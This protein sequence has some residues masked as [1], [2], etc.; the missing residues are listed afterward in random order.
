MAL[1]SYQEARSLVEL[2]LSPVYHYQFSSIAKVLDHIAVDK[3]SYSA[4]QKAIQ[5]MCMPYFD[6]PASRQYFLFQ[7]DTTPVCKPFS[8]TL[9]D[10]TY[11][12]TPNNFIP[13][14]KPLSIGY[15]LSFVN[16]SDTPSAWSLPLSVKRVGIDQ[17]AS[18][19]ALE[20]LK[21]LFAHRDLGLSNTLVINT[22]DSKY[23]NARYLAPAHQHEHLVNIV[24]LRSGIKVWKR[25]CRSNTGGAQGVYGEKYY[26]YAQGQ[27]KTYRHPKTKEPHQVLQRSLFDLQADE[28]LQLCART[29]KGRK[30]LIELWRWN[31]MMIRTRNGHQMKNKPF[32]LIAVRVSDLQNG[33]PLFEREMFI[34]I[35]GKRKAE[36][37]TSQGYEIY[38]HRYNIEPYLRFVKQRLLLE[39]YQTPVLEHFDNW[40]L[41]LQLATWLLYALSDQV[42]FRPRKWEQYLPQNKQ[43]KSAPRL[44][45]AQAR[46]AAEELF[47]TF[48]QTPFK[49]KKSK[50]GKGRRK[51]QAFIPRKRYKVAKKTSKKPKL[52]LKT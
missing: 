9:Q 36:I 25:H 7:T 52:E 11:V 5:G 22:L 42:P 23:G 39:Q 20:Q 29:T 6:P 41:I 18:E 50:K 38:R 48:E 49:P 32:D 35:C 17:T 26:L 27:Y 3:A 15:E 46:K 30:L 4:V 33:L 37:S 44:S 24:R 13:G 45:L 34:A 14:N 47:L 8:P 2:S 19:C 40:L 10:R 1:A 31:D 51:G 28:R 16:L 21:M 12:S 43:T